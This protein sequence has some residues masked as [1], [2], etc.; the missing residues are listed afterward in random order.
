M[1]TIRKLPI[2]LQLLLISENV[3][4]ICNWEKSSKLQKQFCLGEVLAHGLWLR[5]LFCVKLPKESGFEN[6]FDY[7]SGH[8]LSHICK[9]PPQNSSS[10]F[11]NTKTLHSHKLAGPD[12]KS[13]K[14]QIFRRAISWEP[15]LTFIFAIS[16]K[17]WRYWDERF[18][19]Q[20]DNFGSSQK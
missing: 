19:S 2:F 9:C 3:A 7:I 13:L 12:R 8:W 4:N 5:W 10:N 1:H 16:A 20:P 17:Q 15:F 6:F 14:I 18:L 11:F